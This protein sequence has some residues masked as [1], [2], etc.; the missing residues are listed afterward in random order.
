MINSK[1]NYFYIALILLSLFSFVYGFISREDSAGGGKID[2]NNTWTNQSTFNENSLIKSLRN[3]KTSEVGVYINSHFP[4]SY[5]FNKFFNPFSK[6]KNNFILSIFILNLFLPIIFFLVL[7]STYKKNNTYQLACFS[8]ILY[9]SP[10]FRTSSYW[11]G[12]ENYGLFMLI[13]SYY[14]FLQYLEGANNKKLYIFAFSLFSCLCVYFDQKLILIPLIYMYLFF[15]NRNNKN[16]IIFYLI[17]NLILSIPVLSLIYFWGS[18]TSPHDTI[19]RRFGIFYWEQIGYCFSIMLFYLI[20][21]ITVFHKKIYKFAKENYKLIVCLSVLII[22]YLLILLLFPTNYYQWD[23][24]GKGWLHK[25]SRITFENNLFQKIFTYIFFIVS[26]ITFYFV[27][28][29]RSIII[30]F[31]IFFILISLLI[32]PIFQEYFDPLVFIFLALFFYKSDEL[33]N[34]LVKLQYLFS[35]TFLIF[36]NV[37][38]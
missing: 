30:L 20:P 21:Y 4:S 24:L 33:N 12:M 11:A 31:S 22:I 8:S 2:F 15:N 18:L 5:I 35:L 25:L 1:S 10:Y 27:V 19:T 34:K 13:I 6:N 26:I 36:A 17:I 14:F 7:R 29:K 38:Y 23:D 28:Q 16:D 3:T 32:L 37:Y 9:L